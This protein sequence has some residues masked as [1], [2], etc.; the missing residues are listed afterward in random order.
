MDETERP[1]D[2]GPLT[3]DEAEFAGRLPEAMAGATRTP[4][5][6][7]DLV[8]RAVRRGQRL[9]ALRNA[10]VGGSV[11][12]V[13]VAGVLVAGLPGVMST[14][15]GPQTA[16]SSPTASSGG[17]DRRPVSGPA[18]ADALREVLPRGGTFSGQ[19][20]RTSPGGASTE[21]V[22][23]TAHG[24][25]GFM[26][27]LSPGVRPASLPDACLP[28]E[29]RP[30]DHCTTGL[31]PDGA[32]FAS[33]RSYTHPDSDTGQK[34]WSVDLWPRGG[35]HLTLT[36]WGGGGEKATESDVDPVVAPP[37]LLTAAADPRWRPLLK[38]AAS[39]YVP[40][41]NHGPAEG[42]LPADRMISTLRSLLP[43]GTR[44][45]GPDSQDGFAQLVA[46]DGHG[47]ALVA[48]NDQSRM[49][50]S[51]KNHMACGAA[52]HCTS[53]TLADGG[54]WRLYDEPERGGAVSR[55]MDV[56][57]RDGQRVAVRET[58]S[59]SQ[60]TAPDRTT[61]LLSD[62]RMREIALDAA[63]RG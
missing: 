50:D 11:L 46:D 22:Y 14:A 7:G 40:P 51:L 6:L 17:P 39:W 12:A 57:H 56:L 30:F 47:R 29:V 15:P 16:A 60:A 8:G 35:G 43:A 59:F 37:R 48:V 26:A 36:E 49:W 23:R 45:T 58:T 21:A 52:P 5:P 44:V 33:T 9:K 18:T 42:P 2:L 32:A 28:P 38:A 4:P 19:T 13:A 27:V 1:E 54:T 34:L 55:I 41:A 25:S 53:G 63:W 61:Q 3:D 24:T 31:M 62:V 20:V 10:S